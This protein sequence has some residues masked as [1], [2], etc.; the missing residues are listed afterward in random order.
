MKTNKKIFLGFIFI[1]FCTC[2]IHA[3][4]GYGNGGYGNGSRYGRDRSA[5]PQTQDTPEK[6]VPPTAEEIVEKEMPSIKEA[7]ELNPF[8]EAVVSS[9]L[10]KSIKKRME[11]SI[12]QLTP[13][14]TREAYEKI[15]ATQKEELQAGLPKEKYD[16]FIKLQEEGLKKTQKKKKKEKKE[17]K[18]SKD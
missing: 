1:I 10:T 6:V 2:S 9:I 13:E 8:E 16:A 7:L 14:K 11:L 3:Q 4:Y 12:L 17:K 15:Y 18:K 5:I